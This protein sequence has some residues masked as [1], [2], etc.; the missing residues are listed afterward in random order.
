MKMI[1]KKIKLFNY[2]GLHFK[3]KKILSFGYSNGNKCNTNPPVIF[4]KLHIKR[5][6]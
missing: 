4:K 1:L 5:I 2:I 3:A 6:K